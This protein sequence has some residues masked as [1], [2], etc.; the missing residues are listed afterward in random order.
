MTPAT[1]SRRVATAIGTGNPSC[2]YGFYPDLIWELLKANDSFVVEFLIKT[3]SRERYKK[4]VAILKKEFLEGGAAIE[5]L[6]FSYGGRDKELEGGGSK[7]A[8]IATT[9]VR[10]ARE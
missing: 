3:K 4:L 1:S 9:F 10:K 2:L 7:L 8:S 5:R 6:R